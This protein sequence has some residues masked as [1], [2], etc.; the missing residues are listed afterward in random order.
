MVFLAYVFLDSISSME[1]ALNAP[2]THFGME[3]IADVN[4]DIL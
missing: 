3:L 2:K 1:Y 4:Q